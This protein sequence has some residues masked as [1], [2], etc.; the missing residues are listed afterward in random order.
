MELVKEAVA[1]EF[2][3]EEERAKE[4]NALIDE[5]FRLIQNS[6]ENQFKNVTDF[7]SATAYEEQQTYYAPQNEAVPTLQQRPTVTEYVRPNAAASPLFTM[8]TYERFRPEMQQ[9]SRVENKTEEKAVA[10]QQSAYSLTPLAKT[11]MAAFA[12]VVVTM[13]TV[14]CVNT[15]T[16]NKKTQV[17]QGLE[18]QK[19]ELMEANE[20]IQRRIAQAQS[21]ETIREYAQSQGMVQ[22]GQ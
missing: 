11:V 7:I 18:M 8:Q 2:T 3:T 21:E 13:M 15:Q 22:L 12:V 20:E 1:K 10:K 19:Q 17:L 4:H 9:A 5:R 14:I 16:I 6:V